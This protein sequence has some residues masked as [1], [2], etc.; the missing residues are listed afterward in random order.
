MSSEKIADIKKKNGILFHSK[1]FIIWFMSIA[2]M[3]IILICGFL[4]IHKTAIK[5]VDLQGLDILSEEEGVKCHYDKI[6]YEM[7][8]LNVYELQ[9]DGWCAIPGKTTNLVEIRVLL[10]D[11]LTQKI[12]QLPT[13]VVTR[14][15]ATSVIDD[16]N[17]YDNSG[18]S[19][20][21]MTRKFNKAGK[22]YEI[23]L[24]YD[25]GGEEMIIQTNQY[26]FEEK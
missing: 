22:N 14:T 20:H 4:Y 13:T 17:S 5:E 23:L 24:L 10:K 7:N 2:M 6:F 8:F 1:R 11:T 19:V 12:Y 18:F 21:I 16:G 26:L 3:V 25:V 15:E 9:I